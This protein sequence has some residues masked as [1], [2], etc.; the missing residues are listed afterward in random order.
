MPISKIEFYNLCARTLNTTFSGDPLALQPFLNGISLLQT[1]DEENEHEQI[2]RDF[3]LT[4]L[5]GIALECLPTNPTITQIKEILPTKIKPDNSKIITGRMMA[6]QADK[7]NFTEFTNKTEALAE[8]LNRSFISEGIPMKIANELT[9][10]RTIELCRANTSSGI[11]K[12]VLSSRKFENPKEVLAKFIIESRTELSER[13]IS[14]HLEPIASNS[15][16]NNIDA[17]YYIERSQSDGI[18]ANEENN[19]GAFYAENEEDSE[20]E[21]S[22]TQSDIEDFDNFYT[23]DN[24]EI[25]EQ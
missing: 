7:L 24:L 19:I 9:I 21:F 14:E 12:S 20:S 10:D 13:N 25:D 6:I 15:Q 4:K 8:Q 23:N 16:R 3:I 18:P 22:Q 1:M 5:Q 2:L 11:V 17:K